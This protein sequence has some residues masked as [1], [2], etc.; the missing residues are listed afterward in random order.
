MTDADWNNQID[1]MVKVIVRE[2]KP[3]KII[4]FGS[5][6]RGQTGPDSDIDLFVVK[7]DNQA[8]HQRS[9]D[10][11]KILR[12]VPY[13]LPLDVLVYTPEEVKYRMWLGDFFVKRV[14]KEG[15]VLYAK[16]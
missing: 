14:M 1:R 6:A 11:R 13:R 9:V 8:R 10:V 4:L 3:E 5:A 7:N 2:Y 16:Q 15:K 12:G